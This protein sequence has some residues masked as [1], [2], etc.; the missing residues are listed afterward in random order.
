MAPRRPT[1]AVGPAPFIFFLCGS[2]LATC[3]L[4]CG[5]TLPGEAGLSDEEIE[6]YNATPASAVEEAELE[7]RYPKYTSTIAIA[8]DSRD[9]LLRQFQKELQASGNDG[10]PNGISML[11]HSE[12]GSKLS[13]REEALLR[14]AT[15]GYREAGTGTSKEEREDDDF[16]SYTDGD[17]SALVGLDEAGDE[18]DGIGG[19]NTVKGSGQSVF[20]DLATQKEGKGL[21]EKEGATLNAEKDV[22]KTTHTSKEEDDLALFEE[23]AHPISLEEEDEEEDEDPEAFLEEDEEEEE[24]GDE[25]GDE[26][27]E[28]HSDTDHELLYDP[29]AAVKVAH[30]SALQMSDSE[31]GAEDGYERSDDKNG[32]RPQVIEEEESSVSGMDDGAI[33][34]FIEMVP[35]QQSIRAHFRTATPRQAAS[36]SAA[37]AARDNIPPHDDIAFQQGRHAARRPA[38]FSQERIHELADQGPV[39]DE[40]LREVEEGAGAA[41]M[42]NPPLGSGAEAAENMGSEYMSSAA[43]G[44]AESEM[45]PPPVEPPPETR[46]E[47]ALA[48][49]VPEASELVPPPEEGAA[50][51][52]AGPTETGRLAEEM[53]AAGKSQA[54]YGMPGATA[55]AAGPEAAPEGGT[56]TRGAGLEAREPLTR[57]HTGEEDTVLGPVGVGENGAVEGAGAGEYFSSENLNLH[58]R[59]L[60]EPAED[61]LHR[62]GWDDMRLTQGLL[63]DQIKLHASAQGL[64]SGWMYGAA[65]VTAMAA[66]FL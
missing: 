43:A 30:P 46:G 41:E 7:Q 6:Q 63:M 66:A 19:K 1:A 48:T 58:G 27:I 5:Y 22:G 28:A 14:A 39:E 20:E 45:E 21:L 25:F 29:Y 60:R 13:K 35:L 61:I 47:E 52:G 57:T 23:E 38:S 34:S 51:L 36:R 42:G 15:P 11:Q 50:G 64:S 18:Q 44:N 59:K 53:E 10:D 62:H 54:T 8:R 33:G 65:T 3:L 49:A 56:E 26:D 4:T 40:L 31:K 55:A 12:L 37:A 17:A 2:A 32:E 24:E 16:A 9:R